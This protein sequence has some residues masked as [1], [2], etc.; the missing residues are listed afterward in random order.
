[1]NEMNTTVANEN[2][3]RFSQNDEFWPKTWSHQISLIFGHY[4]LNPFDTKH[5]AKTAVKFGI[6]RV[7]MLWPS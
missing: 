5:R 4:A 1:M 2:D 6:F 3:A 7:V